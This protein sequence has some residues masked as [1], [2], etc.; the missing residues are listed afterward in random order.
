MW[1]SVCCYGMISCPC[2]ETIHQNMRP[3][4]I[5]TLRNTQNAPGRGLWVFFS[6]CLWYDRARVSNLLIC[7]LET[8]IGPLRPP[9]L[10]STPAGQSVAAKQL[11]SPS[12]LA[13][14]YQGGREGGG[15]PGLEQSHSVM[16]LQRKQDGDR[17]S[18]LQVSLATTNT[19]GVNIVITD[20][21][22]YF[23]YF[24]VSLQEEDFNSV[25]AGQGLL[26]EFSQFPGMVTQLLEKCQTESNNQQPK[27]ILVLNLSGPQ[28]CLEFT[29][30]NMFKHLVHLSLVLARATDSQLKDYLVLSISRLSLEK[31][32]VTTGQQQEIT[33]LQQR[34]TAS[35]EQLQDTT[36][37]LE[38]ARAELRV[39]AS[40][41]ESRHCRSLQTEKE[42]CRT[43]VKDLQWKYEAEINELQAKNAKLTQQLEN[44]VASLDVQNRDL[45]EVR[46]SHEASLRE[47]RAQLATREEEV[48]RLRRDLAG[49][50]QEKEVVESQGSQ[51]DK[52]VVQLRQRVGQ[53]ELEAGERETVL[54]NQ[55]DTVRQLQ[56]TKDRLGKELGEKQA[57]VEK[58]ETTIKKLSGEILKA[59][60]IISRLQEGVRQEQDK[61]KLRGHIA[62]EQEKLLSDRDR[63][64][65][66]CREEIKESK[67]TIEDLNTKQRDLEKTEQETK[68]KIEELEKI[69]NTKENVINWLNKQLNP[70]NEPA[71]KAPS[72]VTAKRGGGGRAR[73]PLTR[74]SSSKPAVS[75]NKTEPAVLGGLDPA[76]F[77]QSTPG[78]TNYRH[79]IPSHLP[80]NVARGAG[81]VRREL[82]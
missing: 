16:V 69:I 2:T 71:K 36:S 17:Q 27:F 59:N 6:V 44:R 29:E 31:S 38:A 5:K 23:L 3:E 8:W 21:A 49:L 39:Q 20:P 66:E 68:A 65:A 63:E 9:G 40:S 24:S 77:L 12:P 14:G 15:P 13:A 70:E 54:R 58:R 37:Q 11:F 64:L 34:L 73:Q 28:P 25:K 82:R 62:Q 78:G 53:L 79:E 47:A 55:V 35:T 80:A 57:V 30:L 32:E 76:Y 1:L 46:V 72:T 81:L 52:Q 42:N 43:E 50:K 48:V 22:D 60:E 75:D 26:V 51:T 33:E 4:D 19:R 74:L 61:T 45:W 7:E 67:E 56:D 41:L 18:V 10:G